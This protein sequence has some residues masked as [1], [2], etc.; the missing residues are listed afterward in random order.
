MARSVGRRSVKPKKQVNRRKE[1]DI[2]DMSDDFGHFDDPFDDEVSPRRTT[3][4]LTGVAVALP[5]V[6]IIPPLISTL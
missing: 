4:D 5:V 1:V 6:A 3:R 2:F